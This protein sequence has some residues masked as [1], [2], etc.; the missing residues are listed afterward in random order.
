MRELLENRQRLTLNQKKIVVFAAIVGDRLDF[1]DYY[2]IGC[3][4]A[5]RPSPV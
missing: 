2:L 4:L 1:F 5:F 3:V